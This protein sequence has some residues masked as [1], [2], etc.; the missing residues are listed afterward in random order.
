M[1]GPEFIVVGI[2]LIPVLLVTYRVRN[3]YL[4][5]ALILAPPFLLTPLALYPLRH[6]ILVMIWILPGKLNR[7]GFR[8]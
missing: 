2:V 1:Q 8:A 5:W 7:R 6:P 4:M 3:P